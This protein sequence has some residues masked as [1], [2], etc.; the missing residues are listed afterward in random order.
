MKNLAFID[1]E[2]TGLELEHDIWE[3][4]Y[5]I[6]DDPV[7]AHQVPHSLRNANLEALELNGYYDRFRPE[8][9]SQSAD[10]I[11]KRVLAGK[12]LV[13]SNP[14]FDAYR[15]ARRWGVAPWHHRFVDV[16]SM[17]IT[18]FDLDKPEGL[19]NVAERL[20][21]LDHKIP[22]PDHT[23]ARDVEAVRAVY[24]AL[25]AEGRKHDERP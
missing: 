8:A 14:S 3:I 4:A 25:R 19:A 1:A 22:I 21:A 15:L 24:L 7:I 23:A 10:L 6:G 9:V 12:T 20:R 17:A 2:T 11:L 5:A 13:G 18:V 16:S